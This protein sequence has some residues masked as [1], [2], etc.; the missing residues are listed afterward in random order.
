MYKRQEQRLTGN[1]TKSSN[2]E[3][4]KKDS[5]GKKILIA[6][7]DAITLVKSINLSGTLNT[8]LYLPGF[9]PRPVLSGFSPSDAMAP[10]L[11]MLFGLP[12][13]IAGRAG[14]NSNSWL[15]KNPNQPNRYLKTET[16]SFNGRAQLEPFKDFRI[17]MT[18]NQN[19]GSQMSSTFRYTDGLGLD[20]S[21]IHI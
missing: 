17:T 8:G 6:T 4:K 21:L 18:A 7:V 19:Y 2:K 11:D 9:N 5:F 12:I 15:I 13:D 3:E 20:L 1:N 10:G 14:D 16:R